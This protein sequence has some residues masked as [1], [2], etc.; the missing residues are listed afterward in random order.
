MEFIARIALQA[1][2]SPMELKD[3]G[4]LMAAVPDHSRE[5]QIVETIVVLAKALEAQN[6][7]IKALE[8]QIP[9]DGIIHIG[10]EEE[11][12]HAHES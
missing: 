11:R 1:Y 7:R 9:E 5:R 8:H 2:S 10:T 3:L 4:E 12:N 6:D